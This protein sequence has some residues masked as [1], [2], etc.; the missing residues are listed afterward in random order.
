M[1][2]RR[3][4]G[5]GSK[6]YRFWVANLCLELRTFLKFGGTSCLGCSF[7]SKPQ[8]PLG[9]V[10][11]VATTLQENTR[12]PTAI[13]VR[14]SSELPYSDENRRRNYLVGKKVRRK[15]V[16]NSDEIPTST[17]GQYS[18]GY[19][20]NKF[21]RKYFVGNWS[22]NIYDRCRRRNNVRQNFDDDVTPIFRRH[23][24][25]S[26]FPGAQIRQSP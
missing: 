6:T 19:S 23:L 13:F 17:D 25:P 5:E 18:D 14:I 15:F 16:T 12:N 21:H 4:R 26:E 8:G 24:N 10:V 20:D 2:Q 11:V 22:E 7:H 3:N 9:K 1:W